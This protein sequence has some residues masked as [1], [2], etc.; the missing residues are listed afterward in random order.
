MHVIKKSRAAVIAVTLAA[1]ML[2]GGCGGSAR[3]VTRAPGPLTAYRD[4]AVSRPFIGQ[5]TAVCRQAVHEHAKHPFPLHRFD[6]LHPDPAKLPAVADYFAR[7]G[8]LEQIVA[9]LSR[10][11]PPARR[12]GAWYGLLSLADALKTTAQRQIAAARQRDV[13]A[14]VQTVRAVHA[15]SRRIDAAGRRFGFPAQ[16]PCGQVL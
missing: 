6:P 11:T 10:L 13:P 14:F 2:A 15:L 12:A 8:G 7:Y 4:D 1:V 5:V 9:R 16:S 3:P